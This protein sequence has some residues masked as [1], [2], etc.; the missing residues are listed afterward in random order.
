M[1]SS[2]LV[3]EMIDCA[4]SCSAKLF[5]DY[6]FYHIKIVIQIHLIKQ[7]YATK[8]KNVLLKA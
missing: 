8:L 6:Y 3:L 4:K 1:K 7:L 5:A 2:V